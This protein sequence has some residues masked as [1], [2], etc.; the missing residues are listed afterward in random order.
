MKNQFILTCTG[1]E[2]SLN[3]Q[4]VY[5]LS[6]APSITEI[7]HSLA[8]INRFSGHC[9]RPYSVAEHSIL[10]AAIA[11]RLGLPPIGQL[12]AL[13]HDAHECIVGDMASPI[14]EIMTDTWDALEVDHQETLLTRYWLTGAYFE[15]RAVIKQAD[16][17]ALATER[18]DLMV[19][20]PAFNRPWPII[21]TPGAEVETDS[22]DLNT[23]ARELADWT[24]WKT[25]FTEKFIEL[26]NLAFPATEES[27]ATEG[28]KAKA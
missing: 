6:N 7:A 27:S 10:V 26:S 24:T 1:R 15:H 8:Q 20:S 3:R 28:E 11:K 5:K 12:A 4:D 17:I 13:M 14:K 23:R 16:L 19:Y 18:R 22:V 25:Y 21:D 2:H 9:S